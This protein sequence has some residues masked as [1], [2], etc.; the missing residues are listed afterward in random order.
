MIRNLITF[1]LLLL[2]MLLTWSKELLVKRMFRCQ[3]PDM[4]AQRSCL[5]EQE[6]RTR[7]QTHLPELRQDLYLCE[8][9]LSN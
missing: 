8:K 5:R 6:L 4:K 2:W 7:D 3:T 9:K 1:P